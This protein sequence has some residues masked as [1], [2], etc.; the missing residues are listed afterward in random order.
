MTTQQRLSP[1]FLGITALVAAV[2]AFGLTWA[3]RG[4][5]ESERVLVPIPEASSS[6]VELAPHPH[7]PPSEPPPALTTR[8]KWVVSVRAQDGGAP[9]PRAVVR[10]SREPVRDSLGIPTIDD[11]IAEAATNDIGVAELEGPTTS[12]ALGLYVSAPEFAPSATRLESGRLDAVV[13]L[14]RGSA[15]EGRVL[16]S[17]GGVVS[18]ARV[19][20]R[21]STEPSEAALEQLGVA[22]LNRAEAVTADDGTFVV[23]GLAAKGEYALQV[24]S[25]AWRLERADKPFYAQSVPT[26]TVG[27]VLRVRSVAYARFRLVDEENGGPI[28]SRFTTVVAAAEGGTAVQV[29]LIDDREDATRAPARLV[30]LASTYANVYVLR[31]D[32][33]VASVKTIGVNFSVPEYKAAWGRIALRPLDELI[34]GGAADEIRLK[35][36]DSSLRGAV[37][38]DCA[39]AAAAGLPRQAFRIMELSPN[40]RPT[41][42]IAFDRGEPHVYRG[43]RVRS[44]VWIFEN[45]PAGTW[46]V[47]ASDGLSW[48][49]TESVVIRARETSRLVARW[50]APTGIALR[51]FDVDG[52]RVVGAAITYK[53]TEDIKVATS[54]GAMLNMKIAATAPLTVSAPAGETPG[55]VGVGWIEL[56]PGRYEVSVGRSGFEISASTIDVVLGE[57]H[58]LDVTLRPTE[59]K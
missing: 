15:I 51:V 14:S 59:A 54:S 39:R 41:D 23:S 50:S 11:R 10:L 30:A 48:S 52:H 38:V 16:S 34:D 12:G 40:G 35:R 53:R 27:V 24:A 37:E 33:D 18:G 21:P 49:E 8:A 31:V 26:G 28:A 56:M 57:V 43:Q 22:A 36:V 58:V 55:R 42:G 9:V 13:T 25:D 19:V 17:A 7:R 2:L 46:G 32:A 20:A 45:L 6:P 44:D 4:P 47:R 3:S 29:R 5:V 1:T